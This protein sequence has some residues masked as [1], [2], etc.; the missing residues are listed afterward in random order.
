MF[1]H[2][3]RTEGLPQ[4][5]A[6]AQAAGIPIVA[7]AVGGV[8]GAIDHG[9]NGLLIPPDDA[10]AAVDALK[11]LRLDADLRASLITE[12]LRRAEAETMEAQLAVVAAFLERA[13]PAT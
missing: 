10:G 5:L 13:V 12:G 6:E 1:L 9:R 3:S 2:V 8:P 11:R 4:V 7:T